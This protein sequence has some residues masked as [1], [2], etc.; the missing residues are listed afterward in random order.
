MFNLP[1]CRLRMAKE[2]PVSLQIESPPVTPRVSH[3]SS[4][5]A[6]G[7]CHRSFVTARRQR[8][9]I[10]LQFATKR[11]TLR[12]NWRIPRTLN[13]L[14]IFRRAFSAQFSPL[15]KAGRLGAERG[16]SRRRHKAPVTATATFLGG[17]VVFRVSG[18]HLPD[19]LYE[20]VYFVHL[21]IYLVYRVSCNPITMFNSA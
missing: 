1:P 2:R 3:I 16:G 12:D 9:V 5:G 11:P 17:V 19:Y 8:R 4:G 6:D 18:N 10:K 20:L 7:K 14:R 13:T 21:F 15:F